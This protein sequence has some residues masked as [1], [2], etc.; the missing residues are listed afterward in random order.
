MLVGGPLPQIVRFDFNQAGVTCAP[1]DSTIDHRVKKLGKDC[2][3][4]EAA[5]FLIKDLQLKALQESMTIIVF[6]ASTST[7]IESASGI[8]VLPLSSVTRESRR[9]LFSARI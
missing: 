1:Q 3:D 8:V 7:T 9:H 6:P 4:I 5:S 2:D